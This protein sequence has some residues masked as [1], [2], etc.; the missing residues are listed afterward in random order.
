MKTNPSILSQHDLLDIV[1]GSCFFGSGG[2][3]TYQAGCKIAKIESGE[4]KMISLG[5]LKNPGGPEFGMACLA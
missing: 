5:D 4:V 3:G 2:G 1:R